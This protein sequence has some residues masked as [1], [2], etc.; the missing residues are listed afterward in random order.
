MANSN[1]EEKKQTKQNQASAPESPLKQQGNSTTHNKISLLSGTAFII[2]IIA[3]A[4]TVYSNQTNKNVQQQLIDE[5]KT[6]KTQVG[7]LEQNQSG[8]QDLIDEKANKMQ[9][10][11]INLQSRF[12]GLNKELQTAMSQ[13]LYQNQDWILLKA[14]YYL[15]LAQINAHWSDNYDTTIA[16]LLQADTLLNQLNTPKVFDIRQVIAK[17]IAQLK[18]LPAL[19]LAGLLSQIDAAQLSV[20]NLTIQSTIDEEKATNPSELPQSSNPSSWRTR[21]KDNVKLLEKLVVVR[22]TDENIQ[23]LMSPLFESIIRESIRLNLQEAQWAV[24]NNNSAVYQ[25]ALKQAS[26]NI[27]RIFNEKEPNTAALL[28]QLSELQQIKLSQE[29]PE[30]GLALPLLNQ[31]IE[32]N[33][34]QNNQINSEKGEH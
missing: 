21:F 3:L 2:A 10:S 5:N 20:S 30:T 17:E 15:E 14:R 32:H 24:L 8:V 23:P 31:M 7:E 18:A 28:N 29:K 34:L 9:Q 13:R 11:Q 1:E 22:R 16:L 6:L 27:K 4:M 26:T 19:D 12:D 25:L 33:E